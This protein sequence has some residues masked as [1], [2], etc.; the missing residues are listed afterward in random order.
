MDCSGSMEADLGGATRREW[1][2]SLS[3]AAFTVAKREKRDFVGI[4]FGSAKA[5]QYGNV[6]AMDVTTNKIA[7]QKKG[8]A[9]GWPTVCFS[10]ILTTAGNLVFA[11]HSEGILSAYD[12]TTGQHLWDSDKLEGGA[13]APSMTYSVNGKQYVSIFAGGAGGGKPNDT[14][15]AFALP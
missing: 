14:V 11:G 7:W 9:D 8:K 3:M 13:N 12:A 2:G 4:H 10:G 1:A 5:P 6:T 15:Y